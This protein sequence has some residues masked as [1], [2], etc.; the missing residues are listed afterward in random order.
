MPLE[1]SSAHVAG[2]APDCLFLRLPHPKAS[3]QH[4]RTLSSPLSTSTISF[5]N[6]TNKPHRTPF[7]HE[8]SASQLPLPP[9]SCPRARRHPSERSRNTRPALRARRLQAGSGSADDDFFFAVAAALIIRRNLQPPRLHLA[10]SNLF[11]ATIRLSRRVI[12]IF[13]THHRFLSLCPSRTGR[14]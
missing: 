6:I 13:N 12:D 10:S 4:T 11:G 1:Q 5:P 14:K 9:L 7:H 8:P 2:C 3:G